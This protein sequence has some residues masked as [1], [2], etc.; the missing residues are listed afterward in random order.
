MRR[1]FAFNGKFI[2]PTLMEVLDMSEDDAKAW[3]NDKL[4]QKFLSHS[5]WK[6]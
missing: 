4:Q 6:I 1:V 2:I 5:L 3:F